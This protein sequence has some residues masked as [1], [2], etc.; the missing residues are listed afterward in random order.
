MTKNFC[1]RC[2]DLLHGPIRETTHKFCRV[3]DDMGDQ[4]KWKTW[5]LDVTVRGQ[6]AT[7]ATN[8][9]GMFCQRC[10]GVPLLKAIKNQE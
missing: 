9:C 10:F 4:L 5:T 8:E 6:F 7:H 1:D 3:D 2:G